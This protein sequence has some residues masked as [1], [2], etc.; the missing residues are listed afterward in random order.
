MPDL[1]F[2]TLAAS[3]SEE[4]VRNIDFAKIVAQIG[5]FSLVFYLLN[6]FAFQPVLAT[7]DE[8]ER[9]I[10]DG[11]KYAED[12]KARLEEAE[13]AAAS[14]LSDAANE[15]A[16]IVAEARTNAKA[17]ADREQQQATARAED[18]IRKAEA[19]M[20]LERK[21]MMTDIRKEVA[22]LVIST[23]SAIL[24]KDLSETEK[25]RFNKSAAES[26]ASRN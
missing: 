15:A 4:I 9:K 10:A 18:I 22:A 7:I 26:L 14:R 1:S 23:T 12:M 2:V 3:T 6:R 11:L 13:Q 16:R 20:Q 17:F 8:R 5:A 19:A 24:Q 25:S 21:Q